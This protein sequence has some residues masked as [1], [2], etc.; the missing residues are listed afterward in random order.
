MKF[1]RSLSILWLSIFTFTTTAQAQLKKPSQIEVAYDFTGIG[2]GV[3]A[4]L[5]HEAN[6]FQFFYGLRYHI[7]HRPVFDEAKIFFNT[8]YAKNFVQHFGP[9]LGAAYI[10]EIK[11]WQAKPFV[12]YYAQLGV[13]MRRVVLPSELSSGT[14]VTFEED[15]PL[16]R[17]ENQIV[18]GLYTPLFGNVMLKLYSGLG[19]AGLYNIDPRLPYRK[20]TEFG[21]EL[22]IGVSC[23]FN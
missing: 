7:N 11:N 15:S 13:M 18:G 3:H 12:G 8:M 20:T 19:L 16:Y 23:R 5:V 17:W 4:L 14:W 2:S 10:F 9:V 21:F 22:G 1:L 6:G